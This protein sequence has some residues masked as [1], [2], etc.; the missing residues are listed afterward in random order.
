MKSAYQRAMGKYP[1]L[2]T[3]G[4]SA[5]LKTQSSLLLT[6]HAMHLDSVG[7]LFQRASE[8]I[9]NCALSKKANRVSK[10]AGQGSDME[11]II[12]K[13]TLRTCVVI[14][15]LLSNSMDHKVCFDNDDMQDEVG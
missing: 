2:S 12:H 11:E 10:T 15:I 4:E 7:E 8:A 9:R 6:V 14:D 13:M 5:A 1:N 3:Q